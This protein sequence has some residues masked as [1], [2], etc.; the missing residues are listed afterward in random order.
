MKTGE[1]RQKISIP[2]GHLTIFDAVG[3]ISSS[4]HTTLGRWPGVHEIKQANLEHERRA[5]LRPN[6]RASIDAYPGEWRQAAARE[7]RSAALNGDLTVFIVFPDEHIEPLSTQALAA[8][9]PYRGGFPDFPTR[10]AAT[11]SVDRDLGHSLT[12]GRLVVNDAALIQWLKIR[13]KA[14]DFPS[15]KAAATKAAERFAQEA[16]V[17]PKE[18]YFRREPAKWPVNNPSREPRRRGRPATEKI[19]TDRIVDVVE[20][21]LW[22]VDEPLEN[23]ISSL[24]KYG[25]PPS[26][27]TVRRLVE[28]IYRKTRDPRFH[29]RV[30]LRKIVTQK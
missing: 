14:H 30:I 12:K 7:L 24:K 22:S 9:I 4:M 27:D 5:G 21:G 11:H 26:R 28:A 17:P 23:L 10:V 8:I 16:C 3:K 25:Q 13:K 19:W 6:P 1:S 29:R 15:Q 18:R 2:S 20:R